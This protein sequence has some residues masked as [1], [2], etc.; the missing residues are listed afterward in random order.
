MGVCCSRADRTADSLYVLAGVV[1]AAVGALLL[2][3]LPKPFLL[4]G[5]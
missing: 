5:M 1:E 4:H 3:L 2:L